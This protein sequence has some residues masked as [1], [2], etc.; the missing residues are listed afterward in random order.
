MNYI[1][2]LRPTD[3]SASS[4]PAGR[5]AREMAR[6]WGARLHIVPALTERARRAPPHGNSVMRPIRHTWG[7]GAV[8]PGPRHSAMQI[9]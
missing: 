3:F 2:V 4:E 1:E 6:Q 7:R 9:D 5:V 8:L